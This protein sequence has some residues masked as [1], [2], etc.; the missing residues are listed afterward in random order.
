[1]QQGK[2]AS[3]H[4]KQE[5]PAGNTAFAPLGKILS[6]ITESCWRFCRR[7]MIGANLKPGTEPRKV[8][9]HPCR[10]EG[11]QVCLAPEKDSSQCGEQFHANADECS[12]IAYTS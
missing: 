9:G 4:C 12:W 2:E 3:C 1:M 11:G 5:T 7:S 8:F 10:M 6:L